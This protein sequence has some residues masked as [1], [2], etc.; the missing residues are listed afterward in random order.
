[1]RRSF[2]GFPPLASLS[3]NMFPFMRGACRSLCSIMQSDE[4]RICTSLLAK[5]SRLCVFVN[6][7]FSCLLDIDVTAV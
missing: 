4:V 1:M 2:Q 5:I 3:C 6:A 7:K